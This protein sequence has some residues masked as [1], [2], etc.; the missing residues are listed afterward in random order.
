MKM[1]FEL[2]VEI[3][4]SADADDLVDDKA[5]IRNG[6]LENFDLLFVVNFDL[7]CVSAITCW[8]M[9]YSSYL[10]C[11][12][13]GELALKISVASCIEGRETIAS[14]LGTSL[15]IDLA[16]QVAVDTVQAD[17]T[18]NRDALDGV[19]FLELLQHSGIRPFYRSW[20]ACIDLFLGKADIN[21]DRKLH[22]RLPKFHNLAGDQLRHHDARMVFEH[23]LG[24]CTEP[25][26]DLVD[27]IVYRFLAAL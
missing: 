7:S 19:T 11:E 5:A 21:G 20:R 6:C 24:A 25:R 22:I 2:C 18:I 4:G 1:S 23:Q 26:L 15:N 3:H 12:S 17:G 16:C 8:A 9:R 13:N 14:E 27:G 10:C